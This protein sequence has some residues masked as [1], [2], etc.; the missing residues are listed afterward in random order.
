MHNGQTNTGSSGPKAVSR[1]A[2]YQTHALRVG[3][4]KLDRAVRFEDR[5]PLVRIGVLS[6]YVA[7]DSDDVDKLIS[8]LQQFQAEA[9]S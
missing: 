1:Q 9:F 2:G 7:L 6:S 5:K 3:A 8:A 4:I